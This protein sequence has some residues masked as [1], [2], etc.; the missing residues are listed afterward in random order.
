MSDSKI[1]LVTTLAIAG[2]FGNADNPLPDV[3]KSK[4]HKMHNFNARKQARKRAKISRKINRR[5]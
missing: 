3:I 2:A 4:K 1:A 5:G